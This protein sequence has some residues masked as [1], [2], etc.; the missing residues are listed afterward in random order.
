M[1][2]KGKMSVKNLFECREYFGQT[3][4]PPSQVVPNENSLIC[5]WND[6]NLVSPNANWGH[7]NTKNRDQPDI[8]IQ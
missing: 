5:Q 8:T 4:P 1:E 3:P 7:N 2:T 6:L